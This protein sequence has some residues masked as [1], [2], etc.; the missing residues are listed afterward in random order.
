MIEALYIH[1]YMYISIDI[2]RYIYVITLSENATVQ[3]DRTRNET[4]IHICRWNS[5]YYILY[6]Y[7]YITEEVTFLSQISDIIAIEELLLYIIKRIYKCIFIF[8]CV[9][10][11]LAIDFNVL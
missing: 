6:T 1:I 2:Y 8:M 11:Q 5:I 7:I 4:Y 3:L 10:M 9:E